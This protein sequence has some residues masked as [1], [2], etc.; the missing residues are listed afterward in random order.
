MQ[1]V[2]TN[3]G[4]GLVMTNRGIQLVLYDMVYQKRQ[5]KRGRARAL[6][7]LRVVDLVDN[8]VVNALQEG[9][10]AVDPLKGLHQGVASVGE[11]GQVVGDGEGGGVGDGVLH[12]GVLQS[13]VQGIAPL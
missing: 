9:N 5:I 6:P 13:F 7:L 2:M 12:D 11:V 10:R 3:R 1:L 8:H 4:I